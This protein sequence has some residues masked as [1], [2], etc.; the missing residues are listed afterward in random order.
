MISFFRLK[1][2]RVCALRSG[3]ELKRRYDPLR[4]KIVSPI[5]LFLAAIRRLF[6]NAQEGLRRVFVYRLSS[7]H[8]LVLHE[9]E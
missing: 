9:S 7:L 8:L 1:G 5:S 2:K 6:F 3:C 4:F